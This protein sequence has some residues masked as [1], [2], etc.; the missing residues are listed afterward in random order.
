MITSFDYPPGHLEFIESLIKQ[1]TIDGKT[2]AAD[3]VKSLID[4]GTRGKSFKNFFEYFRTNETGETERR[5]IP[6]KIAEYLQN[7]AVKSRYGLDYFVCDNRLYFGFD[8]K[9]YLCEDD[10]NQLR[11]M[12]Q[13]LC[14]PSRRKAAA[15]KEV[16]RLI[17]EKSPVKTREERD[18]AIS[19]PES[20]RAKA[21]GRISAALQ[22]LSSIEKRPAEW[23]IPGY[24]TKN[25]ITLMAGDGGSGKG[26]LWCNIAAAISSGRPTILEEDNPFVKEDQREPKKVIYFSS[27]DSTSVVIKQR[28]EDAGA[29]MENVLTVPLDNPLFPSIKFKSPELK[30]IIEEVRPALVIFDP[31]QSFLADGTMM[32]QR[33]AMRENLNPLTEYSER[34]G[35]AFIIVMHTNKLMGVYGRKRLADS[36]DIWDI[37]RGVFLVGYTGEAYE[38]YISHEKSSYGELQQTVIFEIENGAARFK[39]TSDKKDRDFVLSSSPV[40]KK[41]TNQR[42]EAVQYILEYLK[43]EPNNEAKVSDLDESC[44]ACGYNEGAIRYAKSELKTAKKIRIFRTQQYGGGFMIKLTA[45]VKDNGSGTQGS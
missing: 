43:D 5:V 22:P 40:E 1:V 44:R 21:N 4:E 41:N 45:T 24:V 16:I 34:Y 8:G 30:T 33:N 6:I 3:A 15:E 12:I 42:S 38:R 39:T 9:Y 31:L 27:E 19:F 14:E 28:L 26:F 20:E 23:L 2:M 7:D 18:Q 29:N 35:C 13:N 36:A 32:N 10:N 37:A 11:N 17:K 25:G